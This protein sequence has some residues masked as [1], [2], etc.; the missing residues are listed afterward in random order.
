MLIMLQFYCLAS[1][2]SSCVS[3]CYDRRSEELTANMAELLI[4]ASFQD[5]ALLRRIYGFDGQPGAPA[6]PNRI[7]VD[8]HVPVSSRGIDIAAT[9]RRAGVPLLID[10]QTFYLQGVQHPD[11]R[12]ARLAFGRPDIWAPTHADTFAQ[13]ELVAQVVNY[14]TSHGATAIIPP[15]VN[16]D[17]RDSE[18][19]AVQA[20]LWHRTRR[21]LDREGITL[22]VIAVLAV[23]WRVLHPVQGPAALAPAL[24]AL[25]GLA[26][27]EVA[28]AASKVD[29]GVHPEDRLMDLVLMVE[30]LR[31]DYSV[32]LWQQG[33]LGE[34]GVA[35]GAVGYECGIGWREGCDLGGAANSHR[36]PEQSDQRP[37]RPVFISALG[38][39]VPKR[40]LE[41]IRE[42]RDI[43]LRMI[44]PDA[45]CCPAGGQALLGDARV[46]AIVQRVRHLDQ[47]ARIDRAVWRWQH[48]ADVADAGLDLAD[49]LNRRAQTSQ[50]IA[51]VDAHALSAISAVS[52]T[53]RLDTRS[54]RVA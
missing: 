18:W 54:R 3:K 29:K 4:R 20:G 52:H 34:I 24:T 8:A 16:I 6:R 10:P 27:Q 12:W 9:A 30:R 43:W 48:L 13:D 36:R 19:I 28:L 15:Y 21:Y 2:V 17:R 45:D 33:H 11:D 49:R 22:P 50:A 51:R 26:P 5:G 38:R 1:Y 40:S 35:A 7:V 37:A 44:C 25:S 42:H 41:A 32:I 53:R 14:Q 46:H 23:G 39:S 31:Q 47:I